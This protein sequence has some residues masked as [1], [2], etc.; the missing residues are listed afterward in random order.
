MTKQISDC[1]GLGCRKG[2]AVG[3][4]NS[5]GIKTFCILVVVLV[6]QVYTS[7]KTPYLLPRELYHPTRSHK[8]PSANCSLITNSLSYVN[9]LLIHRYMMTWWRKK[10]SSP[11]LNQV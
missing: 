6:P 3:T 10:G 7:D 8:L 11:F 9:G 1:L 2:R 5:R 4:R